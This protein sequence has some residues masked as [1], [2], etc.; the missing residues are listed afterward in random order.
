MSLIPL[1]D[2]Q[3]RWG[4]SW[5]R[6]WADKISILRNQFCVLL[7]FARRVNVARDFTDWNSYG[8]SSRFNDVDEDGPCASRSSTMTAISICFVVSFIRDLSRRLECAAKNV[9]QLLPGSH[10]RRHHAQPQNEALPSICLPRLI[11][12]GDY[13]RKMP[14]PVLKRQS[15]NGNRME[16]SLRRSPNY[17]RIAA[18]RPSVH[19]D[20]AGS[21]G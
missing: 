14:L 11:V 6:N 13:G 5:T 4:H 3:L 19:R 16:W 8:S 7:S 10:F 9:V 12:I 2:R 1:E 18:V 15:R 20:R 17:L 21:S